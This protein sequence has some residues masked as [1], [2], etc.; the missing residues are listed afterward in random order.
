MFSYIDKDGK[1]QQVMLTAEEMFQG[2]RA[3]NLTPPQFINTKFADADLKIGPAFKQMQASIGIAHGHREDNPFGLREAS[4]ASLFDGNSGF[5]AAANPS[6]AT[7]PF[8]SASRAFTVISIIDAIENAVM[9]D[10]TTDITTF[11]SLVGPR[12]SLNSEHF[13]QPLIDYT[14][15]NGP[16]GAK[17][18]RAVQGANPPRMAFF[19][20][21]NKVRRI[22]S[23]TMGMEFTDQALR[24]TTLDFVSMTLGRYLQVERDERAYRYVSDLYNGNNDLITT[25]VSSVTSNSLDTNANGGVLTHK[26]WLKFLARNRKYRK[27]THV[28]CDLDTYLKIEGRTGRPGSNAYDPRLAVIDPQV[29]QMNIGFGN[30]VKFFLVDDATNGGPVPANTVYA[31]DASNAITLVSNSAAAYSAVESYAMKRTTALRTDWSE[32]V[33]RTFGDSDLKPFDVLTIS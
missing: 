29:Q 30:D 17:A 20:T 9:K 6:Q 16:Q 18:A 13:E 28:I 3:A 12:L 11:Y 14:T 8:G 22:D 27:I 21:S 5:S 31:L 19:T 25:A 23:W 26:A 24:A 32:D 1:Q 7:S 15:D 10:R 33:M 2:A 4:L